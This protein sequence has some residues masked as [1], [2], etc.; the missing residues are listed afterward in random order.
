MDSI[1][2]GIIEMKI[3]DDST[4]M[5]MEIENILA[6]SIYCFSMK[7]N[8]KIT[9]IARKIHA[10]DARNQCLVQAITAANAISCFIRPLKIKNHKHPLVLIPNSSNVGWHQPASF[11]FCTGSC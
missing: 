3:E 5:E 9:V 11:V 7:K 4:A 8:N 2:Y 6:T 10:S 1:N